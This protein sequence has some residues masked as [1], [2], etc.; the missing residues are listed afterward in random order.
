MPLPKPTAKQRKQ[1]ALS[2]KLH[3][4][5]GAM[6]NCSPSWHDMQ[7]LPA[8]VRAALAEVQAALTRAEVQIRHALENIK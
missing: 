5:K 6:G 7:M 3:C 8:H 4:V 1:Q 2:W